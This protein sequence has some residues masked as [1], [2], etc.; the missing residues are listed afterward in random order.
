M[1]AQQQGQQQGQERTSRIVAIP[2]SFQDGDVEQWLEV[3]PLC[4]GQWLGSSRN[5]VEDTPQIFE[6]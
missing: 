6:R 1:Q 2:E 4:R 5:E 3:R